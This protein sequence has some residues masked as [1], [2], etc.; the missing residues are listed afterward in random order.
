MRRWGWIL[1]SG[2]IWLVLCAPAA[3]AGESPGLPPA[4]A[5]K[6]LAKIIRRDAR[7]QYRRSKADVTVT[8]RCCGVRV[9]RV[10]YHAAVSGDITTDDYVLT[11]ETARGTLQ[12]IA[13]SESSTEAGERSDTGR[14]TNDWEAEFSI[15]HESD[16]PDGRWNFIDSYGDTSRVEHNFGGGPSGEGF[17]QACRPRRPVPE[18]LYTEVLLMLESARHHVV[19]PPGRLPFLAC[20]PTGQT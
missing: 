2:C 17:S 3:G 13:I 12:G 20:Q 7:Q 1:A 14:W 15:H 16:G 11:L 6:A 19:S 18:A 9:L 5:A 4:Q 10:H 8:L